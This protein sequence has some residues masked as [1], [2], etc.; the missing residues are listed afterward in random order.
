MFFSGRRELGRLAGSKAARGSE[1][2]L[3]G[4]G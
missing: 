3:D 1:K 4:A 2:D